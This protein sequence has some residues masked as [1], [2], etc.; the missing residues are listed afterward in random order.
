MTPEQRERHREA[1]R[2]YRARHRETPE[3]R[4]RKRE[5]HRRYRAEHLEQRRAYDRKYQQRNRDHLREY[6]RV[7]YAANKERLSADH[8]RLTDP[9][10]HARRLVQIAEWAREWARRNPEKAARNRVAATERRRERK[11]TAPGSHTIEQWA[12]LVAAYGGCCAYCGASGRME[13]DHRIPLS[14]GGGNDIANILPACRPCNRRKHTRT[15]EE[16]RAVLMSS[17]RAETG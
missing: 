12:H 9:E 2:R 15:E 6:K 8:R 1:V 16:F 10:G 3:Q 14:R 13:P 11:R 5:Y 7:Y 17:V 4:E